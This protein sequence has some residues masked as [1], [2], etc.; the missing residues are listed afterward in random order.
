MHIPN[1]IIVKFL[2]FVKSQFTT[3]DQNVFHLDQFT[4]GHFW[5]WIVKQFLT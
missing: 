4:D 1:L 5:S 2:L 3:N